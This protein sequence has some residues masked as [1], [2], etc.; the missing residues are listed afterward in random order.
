M[1][2][3]ETIEAWEPWWREFAWR[4]W[5]IPDGHRI[6]SW[7]RTRAQNAAVHGSPESQHLVALALDV[8]PPAPLEW[9]EWWRDRGL[10][11]VTKAHGTGPHTHIQRYPAG[12]LARAGVD[13][14]RLA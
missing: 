6:S 11:V 10:T 7:Y 14:T 8:S 1:T 13:F 5:T 12:T 3:A 4:V 9:V 2:A